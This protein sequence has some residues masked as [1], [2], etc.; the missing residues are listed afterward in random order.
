MGAQREQQLGGGAGGAPASSGERDRRGRGEELQRA[1]SKWVW[2]VVEG[3]CGSS[4][5]SALRGGHGHGG[6]GE[7]SQASGVGKLGRCVR[8]S[9]A[10]QSSTARCGNERRSGGRKKL[11]ATGIVACANGAV[12]N[13]ATVSTHGEERA[14]RGLI[15]CLPN[16]NLQ[17]LFSTPN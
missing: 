10:E 15:I 9:E 14:T 6:R 4:G 1:E 12:A 2:G 17:I 16:L 3:R 7:R 8:E 13:L 5:G 11:R